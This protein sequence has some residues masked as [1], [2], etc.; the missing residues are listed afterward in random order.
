MLK[1]ALISKIYKQIK[2]MQKADKYLF[3][4]SFKT[5]LLKEK[6]GGKKIFT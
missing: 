6:V 3:S 2:K 4:N 5:K 1:K